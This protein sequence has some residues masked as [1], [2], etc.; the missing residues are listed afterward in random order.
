MPALRIF[1]QRAR[2]ILNR[3]RLTI[4]NFITIHI[5]TVFNKMKYIK[6]ILKKEFIIID[7]S[8]YYYKIIDSSRSSKS[9]ANPNCVGEA[10]RGE[11]KKAHRKSL[12][13][14]RLRKKRDNRRDHENL[15]RHANA[16][17][18][19][20]YKAHCELFDSR[21]LAQISHG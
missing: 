8:N 2:L 17:L 6:I 13:R 20:P 12:H 4:L 21:I 5:M 7:N 18:E 3:L 9:R 16:L 1:C 10:T 15:R 11:H 19:E 14:R